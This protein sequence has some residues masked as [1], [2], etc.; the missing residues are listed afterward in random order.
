MPDSGQSHKASVDNKAA[1]SFNKEPKQVESLNAAN[2]TENQ[3]FS[4]DENRQVSLG[5]IAQTIARIASPVNQQQVFSQYLNQ[6]GNSNQFAQNLARSIKDTQLQ[7][8]NAT[9]KTLQSK[10]E[11]KNQTLSRQ[12]KQNKTGLPDKVKA[13]VERLSGVSLDE[14]SV[15]Y[16]SDKPAQL[17]ALAYTEGTDIHVGPGQEQHLPHEAWHVVQQVQGRVQPTVQLKEGQESVNDDAGLEREADVMGAKA[18]QAEF[19]TESIE[20]TKEKTA[21]NSR[22]IQRKVKQL[23]ATQITLNGS[24]I[25]A[26]NVRGRPDRVFTNSMGDHTT[27]FIVHQEGLLVALQGKTIPEALLEMDKLMKALLELPGFKLM[28][29]EKDKSEGSKKIAT[30][31][32]YEY[33]ILTDSLKQLASSS[34]SIDLQI[35]HLQN[36]VN[37]YLSARE[38]IPFSTINVSE[39][40]QGKAGHGK[41]ESGPA[42][43]LSNYERG[44]A[45]DTDF[46]DEDLVEAASKLFDS[47]SASTLSAAHSTDMRAKMT[48]GFAVES[49]GF[50]TPQDRVSKIWEQHLQSIEMMFPKAYAKIKDK[51]QIDKVTKVLDQIRAE[52]FFSRAK[53]ITV[54]LEKA[55]KSYQD[56]TKPQDY[57]YRGSINV[58]KAGQLA[59]IYSEEAGILAL[60]KEMR[61]INELS[62]KKFTAQ[63]QGIENKIEKYLK[64]TKDFRIEKSDKSL[65]ED[66]N[67]YISDQMKKFW[68]SKKVEDSN[69]QLNTEESE[70]NNTSLKNI[71]SAKGFA[72]GSPIE[73]FKKTEYGVKA[74]EIDSTIADAAE[75]SQNRKKYLNKKYKTLVRDLSPMAIQIKLDDKGEVSQMISSGRPAS[76]FTGTMGAHSTAWVAHLDRVERRIIGKTPAAATA[77]MQKLGDEVLKFAGGRKS[78]YAKH[79]QESYASSEKALRDLLKKDATASNIGDLQLLINALLSFY[80]LIPGV[81]RKKDDTGGKG[82]GTYRRILTN[83]ERYGIGSKAGLTDEA[84]LKELN[85]A[86]NSLYDST[87][88]SGEMWENHKKIIGEAYPD[89]AAFV[90]GKA[91]RKAEKPIPKGAELDNSETEEE[92]EEEVF[93]PL[94]ESSKK[95]LA[96]KSKDSSW[97]WGVNNCLIN[98]IT[99]AVGVARA[100]AEQVIAIRTDIGAAAGEMLFAST[101]ILDIILRRLNL[102]VRGVIVLNVGSQYLDKS[103]DVSANPLYIYHNGINHFD[104]LPPDQIPEKSKGTTA[105]EGIT[106]KEPA[107]KRGRSSSFSESGKEKED[108]NDSQKRLK[109]DISVVKKSL[110]DEVMKD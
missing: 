59:A 51:L 54:Q 80:N 89:S 103:T 95:D 73:S 38:L 13:G 97:L 18:L 55:L 16:N 62:G 108:E 4:T 65:D 107:T 77:E 72:Q 43:I 101:R 21:L 76:P 66:V 26:I 78:T 67:N 53:E 105:K 50:K 47:Y 30:R 88:R 58:K 69:N 81:T 10:I 68:K 60:L 92:A 90:L 39:K 56:M 19:S 109:E 48:S 35:N 93:Q 11:R 71:Q 42:S 41:G 15:K 100:T 57:M 9:N 7:A 63:L 104:A 20:P 40:T 86:A 34:L 28:A 110:E 83:Y 91:K 25:S 22:N 87:A 74:E 27:A 1:P 70:L 75:A 3:I 24:K 106:K 85:E 45:E 61:E 82:E 6:H 84:L 52:E 49:D 79:V 46:S 5:E 32:K 96:E 37:A 94:D 33:D 98:A 31:F 36:A 102:L 8:M 17:G 44:K 12:A 14:V 29:S 2:S 64:N 23:I 99:D